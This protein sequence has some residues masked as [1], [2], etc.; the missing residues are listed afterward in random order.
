MA[1]RTITTR[2]AL[3]GEK[4]FK[5][6]MARVN[7]ELRNL[8]ENLL[9]FEPTIMRIVPALC[10]SILTRIRITERQNPDLTPREAA[11]KVVGRNFRQLHWRR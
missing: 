3:D 2:I 1:T 9:R 10:K 8:Y 5:D 11:E 6:Q 7:G 4:A